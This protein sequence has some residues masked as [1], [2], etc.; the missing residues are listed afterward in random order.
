MGF[1]M[2][3]PLYTKNPAKFSF[4]QAICGVQVWKCGG[5]A[6]VR[7]KEYMCIS[8]NC[9]FSELFGHSSKLN[10][11]TFSALHTGQLAWLLSYIRPYSCNNKTGVATPVKNQMEVPKT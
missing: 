2:T 9:I 7:Y 4:F 6:K 8:Y 10:T 5:S 11:L 1:M 3:I